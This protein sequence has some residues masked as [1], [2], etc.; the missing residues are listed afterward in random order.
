MDLKKRVLPISI[1]L[2]F[3]VAF[4][5]ATWADLRYKDRGNRWEGINDEWVFGYDIILISMLADYEE[6][7]EQLPPFFSLKFYLPEPLQLFHIGLEFQTELDN[8][9]FTDGLRN[10]FKNNL[11]TPPPGQVTVSVE[12]A[13]NRWLVS[14]QYYQHTYFIKKVAERL[15][16]YG[17]PVYL[18]VRELDNKRDNLVYWLDKVRPSEAWSLG[19]YN[20]FQWSTGAVIQHLEPSL[21]LKDL[22]GVVRFGKPEPS[23]NERVA[24]LI[25]YH[26]EPPKKIEGY[27]FRFYTNRD[28]ELTCGI[29]K[30][31]DAGWQKTHEEKLPFILG[32]NSFAV[33]WDSSA[34][35]EGSYKLALY[36]S[37]VAPTVVNFYHKSDVE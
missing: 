2:L 23:A 27:Q 16:V 36:G 5:P 1:M 7:S 34:A 22:G 26:S 37:G 21:K 18:T 31:E 33:H 11:E 32:G 20:N 8:R 14:D 35:T 15:N 12:E 3:W 10:E 17:F 29:Y 19:A 9:K 25:L 13:G 6:P 4:M 24:P 30:K 28:V